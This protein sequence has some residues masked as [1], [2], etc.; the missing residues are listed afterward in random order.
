MKSKISALLDGELDSD[1]VRE[2]CI[3]MRKEDGLRHAWGAYLLIGDALRGEP[4]LSTEMT[5]DV[6]SGLADGPVVLAPR[7]GQQWHRPILALAAT[8]AGVAVVAWLA[9]STQLEIKPQDLALQQLA[10]VQQQPASQAAEN[11]AS[12]QEYLIAH[13]TQS[14]SFYLNGDTQHI[15]TVSASGPGLRR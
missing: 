11:D 15:R 2:V 6:V 1:E 4:Y 13:Q 14:G 10:V 9:L 3:S 8:T 5:R 12:M 7:K